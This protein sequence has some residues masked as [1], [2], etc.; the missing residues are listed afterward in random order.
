MR[1]ARLPQVLATLGLEGFKV[2]LWLVGR[3]KFF[4]QD[5]FLVEAWIA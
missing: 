1:L 4:E 2:Q 5:R 3:I